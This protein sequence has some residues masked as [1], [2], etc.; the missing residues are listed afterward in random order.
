MNDYTLQ[1][2]KKKSQGTEISLLIS[3]VKKH[4]KQNPVDSLCICHRAPD[5][6]VLRSGPNKH[7][8]TPF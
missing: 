1:T 6:T 4:K 8:H 3:S 5:S 2:T 7:V